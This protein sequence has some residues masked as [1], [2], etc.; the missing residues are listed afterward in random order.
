[1]SNQTWPN[2]ICAGHNP[3]Y[4]IY[5]LASISMVSQFHGIIA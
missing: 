2:L 5:L 3:I 4:S 1:M